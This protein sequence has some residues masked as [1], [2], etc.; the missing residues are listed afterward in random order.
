MARFSEEGMKAY[1]T[2]C[3]DGGKHMPN[4]TQE[5]LGF[6]HCSK[7]GAVGKDTDGYREDLEYMAKKTAPCPG[8]AGSGWSRKT[9]KTCTVCNGKG[10]IT[11]DV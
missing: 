2:P 9:G 8:C 11:V 5:A 3:L 4:Q 7:C 1:K 6:F 10:E